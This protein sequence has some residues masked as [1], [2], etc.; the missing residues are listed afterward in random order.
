MQSRMILAAT[1]LVA[2]FPAGSAHAV[3]HRGV[4]TVVPWTAGAAPTIKVR[5]DGQGPFTFVVD[6]GAEGDGWIKPELAAR[7]K[8]A[9]VGKVPPDGPDDPEQDLRLFAAGRLQLGT[10]TFAAPRFGEMLQMGPKAQAFDG[11]I[12]SALFERLKVAFDYRNRQLL[13][14]EAPLTGGQ[15]VAFDRGMPIVPLQIGER[16]VEAHLDTGNIAGPLFVDDAVAQ[17]LPLAGPA[18]AKGTVRTHYGEQSILEAPL[19]APVRFGGTT[20]PVTTV[21]WPPAI[22]LTNLGSRGLEGMLVQIDARTKRIA[23]QQAGGA[24]RCR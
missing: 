2:A 15:V 20:L 5:I 12:G 22:G 4:C 11:I 13:V 21:R 8:L 3:E 17:A 19:A 18:V 24:L 10:M 9:V 7:L 1:L 6:T 23:I 14:M 16:R